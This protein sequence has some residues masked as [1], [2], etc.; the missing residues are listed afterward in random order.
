M[1]RLHPIRARDGVGEV[2]DVLG[3]RRDGLVDLHPE[4][5]LQPHHQYGVGEAVPAVDVVGDGLQRSIPTPDR[6]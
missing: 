1:I 3:A 4:H 2:A 5:P 6:R